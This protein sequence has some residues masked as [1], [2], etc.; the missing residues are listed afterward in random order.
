MSRSPAAAALHPPH[1]IGF[2][3]GV[4]AL[5]VTLG[6]LALAYGIEAAGRAVRQ[7]ATDTHLVP[8]TIGGTSLTIPAAWLLEPADA[9]TG[10]A[11]QVDLRVHL[12][13]G[14]GGAVRS[15]DVT[16]TQ[17][18]RVRPSASLLDGV[19]LH[20]F[21]P[22]QLGG[23]VGLVGKPMMPTE[24]YEN[25]TVWYDP[26]ASAPFVAKCQSPLVPGEPGRCLRTVYLESG[27]AAV[28]RFDADIL[29]NWRKFDAE[30]HPLLNE[31]GAV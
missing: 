30:M 23:P 11:R 9:G 19:Y 8:R 29:A 21:R 27:I 5:L 16:L 14:P 24:G 10:F 28:Y 18:S 25:E 1:S 6:G 20:Q 26:I 17:R 2:N 12:P 7:A 13:L 31:I 3:L 4:I 15:V 22:E